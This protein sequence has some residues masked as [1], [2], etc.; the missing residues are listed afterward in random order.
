V[1]FVS[2]LH[3]HVLGGD[4]R[5]GGV[6]SPR[7]T[8]GASCTYLAGE[9]YVSPDAYLTAK[10]SGADQCWNEGLDDDV[11]RVTSSGLGAGWGPTFKN[12]SGISI[13]HARSA[14]CNR[15]PAY[16]YIFGSAH[17]NSFNM[18]F[19]DGSVQA[20]PYSIDRLFTT[21]WAAETTAMP[22]TRK[23]S[24][25]PATRRPKEK[26]DRNVCPADQAF[27]PPPQSRA[28]EN[29]R[30]PSLAIFRHRAA[31]DRDAAAAS[32]CTNWSSERGCCLSSPSTISCSFKRTVS[33]PPPRR[34]RWWCR[35][36]RNASAGSAPRRLNPLSSTARLTWS[37]ERQPGRRSAA[38]SA[39]S[40]ASG[41]L[42]RKAVW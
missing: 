35:R 34:R 13:L 6:P 27:F 9:K 1:V 18:V 21:T 40:M 30:C 12:V 17:S 15:S 5:A 33:K 36:R 42:S 3:Q 32:C 26:T 38:S 31:G 4:L 7:H 20:I 8:D 22:S 14:G 39:V 19:C 2:K 37:R 16:T 10:D 29:S 23:S 24:D 28:G 11:N 41:P 25:S